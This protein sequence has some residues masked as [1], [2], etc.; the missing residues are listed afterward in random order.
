[1]WQRAKGW[2]P[3]P[4]A[5][6]AEPAPDRALGVAFL[7]KQA[8][9]ITASENGR[10]RIWDTTTRDERRPHQ[11]PS[12]GLREL[13]FTDNGKALAGFDNGQLIHLWDATT[14]KR[15]RFWAADGIPTCIAGSPDGKL[16]AAGT[17]A[18]SLYC[19]ELAT[20]KERH[21]FLGHSA[22]RAVNFSLDSRMLAAVAYAK[23]TTLYTWDHHAAKKEPIVARK[24]NRLIGP[25]VVE[26]PREPDLP[27]L[28]LRFEGWQKVDGW[29]DNSTLQFG[30]QDGFLYFKIGDR[31]LAANFPTFRFDLDDQYSP[32]IWSESRGRFSLDGMTLAYGDKAGRIRLLETAA[33][34]T[35]ATLNTVPIE[36]FAFSPDGRLLAIG[37][38]TGEL[39]FWDLAVQKELL[40]FAAHSDKITTL[41]FSF[42]GQS[43]A[44]GSVDTQVL[45]WD[46]NRLLKDKRPAALELTTAEFSPL[47]TKLASQDAAAAYDAVRRL[48]QSPVQAA[49]FLEE[50]LLPVDGQRIARLIADLDSDKFQVRNRASAELEQLGEQAEDALRKALAKKP[51]LEVEKRIEQVLQTIQQARLRGVRAVE[52]LEQINTKEALQLLETLAH[53]PEAHARTREA[54]AALERLTR[55]SAHEP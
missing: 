38:P 24:I 36:S 10:L 26:V 2:E 49:R 4:L 32:D 9:L 15:L 25:H 48:E 6:K 34:Q 30:S 21:T 54:Q 23:G 7:P 45:V 29:P 19:W 14:G 53:G 8:A 51:P 3:Q 46:V 35:R 5:W 12:A 17:A 41:A 44:T 43:L 33:G 52:V 20:G 40:R 13:V 11:G 28:K 50:R 16:L 22:V 47:W 1:L 37:Q 39:S 18:G 27:R 55:R 42:D 31:A